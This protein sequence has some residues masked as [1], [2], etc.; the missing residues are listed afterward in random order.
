MTMMDSRAIFEVGQ[1]FFLDK[2]TSVEIRVGRKDRRFELIAGFWR[3]R[4]IDQ[5]DR[6]LLVVERVR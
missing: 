1:Q 5:G 3:T 6:R 4:I 2:K